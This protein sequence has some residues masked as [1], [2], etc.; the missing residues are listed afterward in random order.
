MIQLVRTVQVTSEVKQI[1]SRG[2][3]ILPSGTSGG[4]RRPVGQF[5]VEHHT[6]SAA[7]EVGL[8]PGVRATGD[9]ERR[10]QF[11]EQESMINA[12]KGRRKVCVDCVGLHALLDRVPAVGQKTAEVGNAGPPRQKAVLSLW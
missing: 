10:F 7:R 6:L 11:V 2:P 1:K 8:D 4:D 3:Q 12:C 5:A 9:I